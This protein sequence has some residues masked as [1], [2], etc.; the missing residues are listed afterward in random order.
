[1]YYLGI[2]IAKTNHVA[3]LI[4]EKGEVLLRNIKFTN[5]NAGYSKLTETIAGFGL[6]MNEIS[7][8]ME[9]TGYYWLALFSRLVDEGL[10]VSVYNPFQIK[11]YRPAF[12]LRKQKNDVIDSIIIADYHR[13]FGSEVTRLPDEDV[14]ALRQLTRYRS[15]IVDSIATTKT[16]IIGILDKVF[17]EYQNLFCD[18][19]GVTSK[20]ILKNCPTPEDVLSISTTKLSNLIKKASRGR[21]GLTTAKEIKELAKTSFGTK[22]TAQAC[23]FEIKQMINQIEFIEQQIKE[24]EIEIQHIYSKLDSHLLSIPGIGDVYA[25]V[26]ISEIGDINSF[27]KPSQLIAY[28]GV[29]P[30]ENQSGNKLSAKEKTSKRGSPHLRRAIYGAALVAIRTDEKLKEYYYKKK[31]EGKHHFVALTGIARKLLTIIFHILK[32]QRDYVIR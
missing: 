29:D 7:Y 30:S 17:P 27:N 20:Q 23:S 18:T 10:S 25:P 26:I 32:E 1:M 9:A 4:D 3:S 15:S 21:F 19:F 2:D 28:A 24:L 6:E 22:Y 31:A 14:L 11:S 16:Q 8:S 13:V 5:S 12:S